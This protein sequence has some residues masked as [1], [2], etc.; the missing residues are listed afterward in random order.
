MVLSIGDA[1]FRLE[2]HS[3]AKDCWSMITEANGPPTRM[4]QNWEDRSR[5]LLL[6]KQ[7]GVIFLSIRNGMRY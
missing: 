3:D 6:P 5:L 7:A 2:V 1:G 4:C